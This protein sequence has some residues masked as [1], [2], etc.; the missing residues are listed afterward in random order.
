[1]S[2]GFDFISLDA[3]MLFCCDK[4]AC[5][6]KFWFDSGFEIVSKPSSSSRKVLRPKRFEEVSSFS[7]IGLKR[8]KKT[9]NK[10]NCA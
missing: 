4:E 9:A 6:N 5:W 2:T 10:L 7:K 8:K 1:M 3:S